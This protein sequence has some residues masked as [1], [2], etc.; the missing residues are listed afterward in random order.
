MNV[1]TATNNN[2]N[3]HYVVGNPHSFKNPYEM[4]A[5]IR[6]LLAL[7]PHIRIRPGH[8]WFLKESSIKKRGC[9]H[10]DDDEEAI[11]NG[12]VHRIA[13]LLMKRN[14]EITKLSLSCHEERNAK[15]LASA[16]V[17]NTSVKILELNNCKMRKVQVIADIIKQ[18]N[19][20]EFIKLLGCTRF[21]AE[22][23]KVILEA[24]R[25][26]PSIQDFQIHSTGL[27][28][29]TLSQLLRVQDN[30]TI[31]RMRVSYDKINLVGFQ[32]IV[33]ALRNSSSRDHQTCSEH[34]GEEND[35][36][37]HGDMSVTI[38]LDKGNNPTP[39]IPSSLGH[40]IARVNMCGVEIQNEFQANVLS[41]VVKDTTRLKTLFLLCSN[42]MNDVV[43]THSILAAIKTNLTLQDL[44]LHALPWSKLN[45]IA[46]GEAISSI[47]T[48]RKVCIQRA[49]VGN[50]GTKIIAKGL[51]VNKCL[52]QLLLYNIN[53]GNTGALAIASVLRT[54]TGLERL[55]LRENK[56]TAKGCIALLKSLAYNCNFG[57]NGV[58]C[59]PQ[60]RRTPEIRSIQEQI[61]ALL[62][63]TP[64][65]TTLQTRDEISLRQLLWLE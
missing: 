8:L 23:I 12:I 53:M 10:F 47:Q 2:T 1:C 21:G 51:E 20:F 49:S 58:L 60:R 63:S 54:N 61:N 35:Q 34:E 59:F 3:Y 41:R 43:N 52:R 17:F 46:L 50:V 44:T 6:G 11:E 31:R 29:E 33:E 14:C 39:D 5:R 42:H 56:V 57:W 24:I 9:L 7:I 36:M 45:S 13:H 19:T 28:N 27:C 37:H 38:N 18:N 55:D 26:H 48:L 65:R 30:P 40:S 16:L 22:G 4:V 62:E 32:A 25:L 64:K 15:V